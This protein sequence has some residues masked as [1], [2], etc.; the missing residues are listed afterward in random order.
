MFYLSLEFS[1]FVFD[2]ATILIFLQ[3]ITS[4][5]CKVAYRIKSNLKNFFIFVLKL[6]LGIID[7]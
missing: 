3:V 6:Y 4:W 1:L 7:I 5:F 2:I